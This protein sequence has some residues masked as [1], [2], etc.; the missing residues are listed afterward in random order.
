MVTKAYKLVEL[1]QLP[2]LTRRKIE[3]LETFRLEINTRMLIGRVLVLLFV[4]FAAVMPFLGVVYFEELGLES[5]RLFALSV[6]GL[7]LVVPL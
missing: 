6:A 4:V 3:D 2:G 1:A 5:V 7:T